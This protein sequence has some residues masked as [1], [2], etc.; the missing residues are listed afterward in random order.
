MDE[1]EDIFRR[2][3][4]KNRAALLG[5]FKMALEAENSTKKPPEP[6][7]Q[8]NAEKKADWRETPGASYG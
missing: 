5:C 1:A 6:A 3:T 7:G 4:I 2:L 8:E